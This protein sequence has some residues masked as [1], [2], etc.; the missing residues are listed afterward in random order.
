[1]RDYQKDLEVCERATKGPWESDALG[2]VWGPGMQEGKYVNRKIMVVNSVSTKND[3]EFIA[4]ARTA[5]PWYIKRCMELE[6]QLTKQ[7]SK[8]IAANNKLQQAE[9]REDRYR[10]ALEDIEVRCAPR[11]DEDDTHFENLHEARQA[12]SSPSQPSRYQEMVAVVEAA[13]NFFTCSSTADGNKCLYDCDKEPCAFN[14]FGKVL[15]S[16]DKAG[17]GAG[18]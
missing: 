13:R 4:I 14:E 15:E 6:D 10:E 2:L 16:Y 5:L 8:T 3:A 17:E 11:A 12:L 7:I 18:K 9:E 1:M